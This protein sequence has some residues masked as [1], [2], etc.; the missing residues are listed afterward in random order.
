LAVSSKISAICLKPSFL[1]WPEKKVYR[2]LACDSPAK[3]ARVPF[4]FLLRFLYSDNMKMSSYQAL[5]RF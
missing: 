3:A 1:A 5:R 2:F 4:Y